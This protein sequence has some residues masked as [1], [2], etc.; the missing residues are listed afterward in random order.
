MNR[1]LLGLLL[2]FMGLSVFAQKNVRPFLP[3]F[4][5]NYPNVRDIAISPNGNE[6]Y[7]TVDDLKSKIAVLAYIRKSGEG[8]STPKTV[9]F[10]GNF[11]DLE[12]AF[13][14]DGDRLFFVSNR[15]LHKDSIKPKDYDIWY[16][17]KVDDGWSNPKNIGAPINTKA[18]EF[19]PSLTK[20][21]DLYFTAEREGAVGREDIFVSRLKDGIYQE[22][23]SIKGG[24][25]HKIF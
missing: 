2:S 7:F 9:S 21:G 16:V 17:D 15:P 25:K 4:F 1:I 10:T 3:E 5:E 19:Y 11:R 14:A 18:H 23:T 24:C 13:S 12:P 6:V 8:W 20:N 22:P